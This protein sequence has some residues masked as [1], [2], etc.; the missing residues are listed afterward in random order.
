M[1]VIYV[2]IYIY[3]CIYLYMCACV[4]SKKKESKLNNQWTSLKYFKY[5]NIYRTRKT[6]QRQHCGKSPHHTAYT[7]QH[8]ENTVKLDIIAIC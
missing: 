4:Y 5:S 8:T 6:A 3:T 7:I 1:H 2:H